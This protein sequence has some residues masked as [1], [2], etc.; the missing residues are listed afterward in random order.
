MKIALGSSFFFKIPVSFQSWTKETEDWA[1]IY[2][3]GSDFS[4]SNANSIYRFMDTRYEFNFMYLI[5][6]KVSM[7][8]TGFILGHT[9][10]YLSRKW[11]PSINILRSFV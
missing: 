6:C 7:S 5:F 11:P 1:A 9:S 2:C 3:G 10:S 8:F 4:D